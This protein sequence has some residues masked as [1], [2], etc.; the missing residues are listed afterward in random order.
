V[1]PI[2]RL[3]YRAL[4][5]LPA[6][7]RSRLVAFT[8]PAYRIGSAAVI[9]DGDGRV[10][11]VHHAYRPG[12]APP[13][14]LAKR[15]EAPETTLRRELGE[16]LGIDVVVEEPRWLLGHERHALVVAYPA[17]LAPGSAAPAPCSPEILEADWFPWSDLP[18]HDRL[19]AWILAPFAPDAGRVPSPDP[20]A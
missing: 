1:T 19:A 18:E 7:V 20:G 3:L 4:R 2:L 16:E 13:G 8:S 10:L 17:R 5:L 11:L 9:E 14:G 6:P 12:W 15:H